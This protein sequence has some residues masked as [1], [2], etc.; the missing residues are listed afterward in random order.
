MKNLIFVS[1][2]LP[3][4]IRINAIEGKYQFGDIVAFQHEKKCSCK[5]ALF[6]HYAIYVGDESIEGKAPDQDIFHRTGPFR[7]VSGC[8]FG[9]L[10]EEGPNFK[11]NF[12]DGAEG[13]TAGDHGTILGRIRDMRK[14]CKRYNVFTNNCEHLVTVVRYGKKLSVQHGTIAGMFWNLFHFIRGTDKQIIKIR[15]DYEDVSCQRLCR[16]RAIR[17]LN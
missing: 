10:S 12:L 4:V 3:L 7:P 2:F 11:D 17:K 15:P 6:K 9:K 14:N 5:S 13:F 1:L 16:R 8:V